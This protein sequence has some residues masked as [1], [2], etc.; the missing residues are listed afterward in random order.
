MFIFLD[1][2]LLSNERKKERVQIWGSGGYLGGG[3]GRENHNQ[4][5][6]HEKSIIIFSIWPSVASEMCAELMPTPYE[7]AAV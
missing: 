6:L 3:E 2:C 4:N 1:V 5:I 7:K